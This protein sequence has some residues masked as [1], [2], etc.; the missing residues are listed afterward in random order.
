MRVVLMGTASIKLLEVLAGSWIAIMV[1]RRR[2][3]CLMNIIFDPL[4]I[5]EDNRIIRLSPA[6]KDELCSLAVL[7]PLASYDL[8]AEFRGYVGATDASGSWMAG[9][10]APLSPVA[11]QELARFSLK[12]STWSRLLPPGRA[13]LREKG[14]LRPDEE[15]P[16]D[17]F[18]SHPIW[19]TLSTSLHYTES[20]RCRCRKEGHINVHELRAFIIEEKRVARECKQK[21]LLSGL[22]SQVALGALVK[23]RSS[24][25]P[26]NKLLRTNLCYPL[27]SG[28][29]NYYMYFLSEDNR[30]DGPTRDSLPKPPDAD[31]P[32]WLTDLHLGDFEAFDSFLESLPEDQQLNPFDFSTLMNGKGLDIRPRSQLPK[33]TR[34]KESLPAKIEKKAFDDTVQKPLDETTFE[35][36][37]TFDLKQFFFKGEAP[38]FSKAGGLDLFS[39]NFGVAKQM[40][41]NGCPWVLTFDWTRSAGENLL[42][43]EL[44]EKLLTLID[45]GWFGSIGMAPICSSFSPAITPPVRSRRYLRGRP[46]VSRSMRQKLSEGNSHGDFCRRLM[47]ICLVKKI[48]FFCENPDRSWLWQQKGYEQFA[49]ADSPSVFRLSFC[50]FGTA[51]QKNTRIA[52]STRLR[53]LRMLCT[54][55][56]PH[57]ALRGYSR[58]HKKCWTK[59]AE[60]YPRGLAKLLAVALCAEAQWCEQKRLN[61]SGCC[62]CGSMRIGEASHPGPMIGR[63]RDRPSLEL[64]PGVSAE[65]LAMESRLLD[66]FLEWCGRTLKTLE[67]RVLFDMVPGFAAQCLRSYGDLCFQQKLSLANFRHLLIGFQRWKPHIKPFLAAAWDLVKRWELQQPVTHRLPVPQGIVQAMCVMAWHR[68]WFDWVGLTLLAYYGAGRVG[69]VIR[70]RRFDLILPCDTIGEKLPAAFLQLRFFKSYFRQGARVQH[71]KISDEPVVK[72]LSSIYQKLPKNDLLFEGT[73]NQYRKRWDHLLSMFSIDK[74]LVRLTPGGLRGGA[75][76]RMYRDNVPIQQIMWAL[77]LRQR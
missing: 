2:M 37:M 18:V 36:L 42:D 11:V 27:G 41:A 49:K 45:A 7:G 61:V 66:E 13:Y 48:P 24:S 73:A 6:L 25:A 59:V 75:A 12:K 40:I 38:D 23:G 58:I 62:R 10:R 19:K 4:A 16:G 8:R 68:G 70:C 33:A 20:W 28:I 50:R 76:V 1:V 35:L 5:A 44:R 64:L 47:G 30:A 55:S 57:L 21:R 29:F 52:T 39:G 72:L 22:D 69:E 46:G 54:C 34:L 65:T 31:P 32:Q 43:E 9:V 56:Q 74:A 71:M 77:R 3:L 67:A 51:W 53:S 15:L 60:P 17:S 26:L 14:L 63:H